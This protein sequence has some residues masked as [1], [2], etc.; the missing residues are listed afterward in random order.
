[1]PPDAVSK[2]GAA[3]TVAAPGGR[4]DGDDGE[5][6]GRYPVAGAD[7]DGVLYQGTYSEDN[8]AISNRSC[9]GD[10]W[11]VGWWRADNHTRY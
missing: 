4:T 5:L 9:G 2:L 11:C 8:G 6:A 10:T 3:G 1:M 7:F